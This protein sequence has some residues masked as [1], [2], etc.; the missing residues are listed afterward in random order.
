MWH[1]IWG[2]LQIEPTTDVELI[3]S[4][5]AKQ[6]K[7]YHPEE[8]PLEFQQLQK[9]Y[10][11]A[12]KYASNNKGND[13]DTKSFAQEQ[14]MDNFEFTPN[15][16][17][18]AEQKI[19]QEI[20]VETSNN[21]NHTFIFSKY[22]TKIKSES[23]KSQNEDSQQFRYQKVHELDNEKIKR[24]DIL[25]YQLNKIYN[26][27]LYRNNINA[28][29]VLFENYKYPEDFKNPDFL[30]EFI[31]DI[32]KFQKLAKGIQKY[33]Y[34]IIFKDNNS[35]EYQVLKLKFNTMKKPLNV[36]TSHK[37]IS[38]YEVNKTMDVNS[39]KHDKA[40]KILKKTKVKG[41]FKFSLLII[42][43]IILNYS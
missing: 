35:E 25:G 23:P 12:I 41:Q 33:I 39:N 37:K 34:N 22:D 11:A 9:A 32:L 31:M 21:N 15:R 4:A 17:V 26:N 40:E 2:W 29:K 19:G 16:E 28:W 38:L 36:Y 30:N 10:K 42:L 18:I 24:L 3:R 5:Y 20:T 6:A 7:I 13:I 43:I 14:I 1:D 27:K 8:Q